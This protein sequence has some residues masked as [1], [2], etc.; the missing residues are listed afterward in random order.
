VEVIAV[1]GAAIRDH[2]DFYAATTDECAQ[3]L[4][5]AQNPFLPNV[6]LQL[7]TGYSKGVLT[8]VL[9]IAV[10]PSKVPGPL[11]GIIHALDGTP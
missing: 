2:I 1:T 11:G 9:S 8:L 7:L 4:R 10:G 5:V 3:L 6:D